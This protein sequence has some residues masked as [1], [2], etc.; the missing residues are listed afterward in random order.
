MVALLAAGAL[1]CLGAGGKPTDPAP[2]PPPAT[3][4]VFDLPRAAYPP[5]TPWTAWSA[6]SISELRHLKTA[7]GAPRLPTPNPWFPIDLYQGTITR[8]QFEQKLHTLYDPFS[9][10]TPY[11]DINDSRVVIYPAPDERQIPQFVLQF[12]PPNQSRAPMR[13]F[14]TPEEVRS[15]SHPL[16]K[17]LNGLRVAIDPGHIGG[18][19]AQMEERSTRYRGSAPVQEGNLNLI[20]GRL[21]QQELTAMGATVFLTRDST[22]P[23]TPYR[24]DDMIEQARELLVAHSNHAKNLRA[25]PPDKLNLLFGQRLMELSE[26][27]FYRCSEIVER[28]NRIRNNFVPDI[29]VTLYIDATPGSGRGRLTSGNAN[30]FFVGGCYTRSEM[31]DPDMRRRCVYKMVEG[32]S[33][34]EKEVAADISDVF[35]QRTGLGPVE[36]GDSGTTRE[37]IPGNPYVVAR[38][39]AA[40]RVY[41]GPVVCTEPYFMNNRV[42]YQRLLAGDYEGQRTFNGKSYGSI[43]REYADCV[44][45]G[46]VKAYA[47]S[48]VIAS[49][50]KNGPAPTQTK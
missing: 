35:K 18:P 5:V 49:G 28:G 34:I 16:D 21:L 40:N 43:F 41:D 45:Q 12:A 38:N 23:V 19:W 6:R 42:V 29:T 20:T 3:P 36:Y 7:T 37:V 24:P 1:L 44:A 2:A 13:W 11:L 17:P 50:P 48:T 8:R 33:E 15:M 26:F 22:E 4:S 32:G 9:A 31:Q 14:R 25:L 46:L 47:G 10:F 39:L 27:L 30:I